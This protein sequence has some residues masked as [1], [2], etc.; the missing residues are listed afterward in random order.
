MDVNFQKQGR[1]LAITRI[2]LLI[3]AFLCLNI[4]TDAQENCIPADRIQ[5]LKSDIASKK[6]GQGNPTL[7]DE[8]LSM[9]A[10]FVARTTPEPT[11]QQNAKNV[12]P[13]STE[14]GQKTVERM[15]AIL[16]AE[17][18]PVK[19]TVGEDG[20]S[21]WIGLVKNYF[22]PRLQL[23]LLPV[24]SAGV[25][26]DQIKK[27]GELAS[28]ID[29]L[30]LKAAQ[31][32]LFGT[33]AVAANG[34]LVLSPLLSEEK[35][36]AWRAEYGMVPL[37]DYIRALQITYHM[38]L[39]RS[40]AKPSKVA[41]SSAPSQERA[42]GSDLLESGSDD[43]EV[44]KINTSLVSI[45]A[46]VYGPATENLEKNN[47]KVYEDGQEQEINVFAAPESPFDIVLLLDLSGSTSDEVGLI[48]RTTKRFIEMKRDVDRVSIITFSD[49][50]TVVSPLEADKTKLLDC[51]SNIKDFGGSWVWD[52]EKFVLDMLKKDSPANHRKAIVIMTD[53]LDNA[54]TYQPGAGSKI[55]FADLVEEV[56]NSPVAIFP[57]FLNTQR[58]GDPNTGFYA[59]ARRTLQLLADESG[60]NYYTTKDIGK[61]SEVYERVLRDVGRVYSLSYEPKNPKRD[62]SWR[63]IRVE[64][65]GRPDLK[66]RTR[67][68]YYAK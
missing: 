39:I 17:P 8:I 61:L 14:N 55:L 36:D 9:K 12:L 13:K 48:K 49:K 60:G 35:V 42:V 26:Q 50:Q 59:D 67:P 3:A 20:A 57:I 64:I 47:F 21:A 37:R 19:S 25:D 34:F 33:Q 28:L 44:V 43:N 41:V 2:F 15:C 53:G 27:D 22:S 24:I 31:P 52:A 66:V 56:R 23:S 46:T 5:A 63:S 16:N 45:D 65:P 1:S 11:G 54:L 51:V 10:D 62:G 58:G 38:P 18:W 4:F 7:K 6:P 30:R 68:G 32:Q 40:T 29:R